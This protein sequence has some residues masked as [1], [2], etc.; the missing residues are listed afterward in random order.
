[1]QYLTWSILRRASSSSLSWM[2]ASMVYVPASLRLSSSSF[3]W[4]WTSTVWEA[5]AMA[6]VFRGSWIGEEVWGLT[7]SSAGGGLAELWLD[8]KTTTVLLWAILGELEELLPKLEEEFCFCCLRNSAVNSCVSLDLRPTL[9][10]G[11][12]GT[13][14]EEREEKPV[15]M[16]SSVFSLRR[17]P[18]RWNPEGAASFSG[19]VYRCV[20]GVFKDVGGVCLP[21]EGLELLV[22]SCPEGSGEML[23]RVFRE[24]SK[25]SMTKAWW[26]SKLLWVE[27]DWDSA[28]ESPESREE[29][30]CAVAALEVSEKWSSDWLK[31]SSRVGRW[32][33]SSLRSVDI[34]D[35][36]AR[37]QI[38][39]KEMKLSVKDSPLATSNI[40][41]SLLVL[42][43]S[44]H[45]DFLLFIRLALLWTSQSATL[46]SADITS[47]GVVAT[48]A[49]GGLRCCRK[50]NLVTWS[51]IFI[52][53]G[54]QSSNSIVKEA[55]LCTTG[56]VGVE[57]IP[58]AGSDV[59]FVGTSWSW[60]SGF[61]IGCCCCN[62][63]VGISK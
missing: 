17:E 29:K 19:I 4:L 48:S 38:S 3:L 54:V 9:L 28:G 57:G 7:S 45:S 26:G 58:W 6:G 63:F 46:F 44:S 52:L 23:L 30:C 62:S 35:K 50:A 21:P 37:L 43:I 53:P 8:C 11:L 34:R 25:N 60:D 41:G 27:I 59:S 39:T 32:L 49:A 10:K 36:L 20:G 33:T 12:D 61:F 22:F 40:D 2:S 13:E 14:E 47:V 31:P 18:E 55:W 1:M 51:L 42:Y 5:W 56:G 16:R 15:L 24:L